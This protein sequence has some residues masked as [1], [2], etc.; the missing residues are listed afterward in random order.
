MKHG[1][2]PR[3]SKR[4]VTALALALVA[5][6]TE[7]RAQEAE[8]YT[9]GPGA[10]VFSRFG[11]AALCVRDA[12]SPGGRCYNY[13]TTDFS[14]P[15]P[16][17]WQVLRGRARFWVSVAPLDLMLAWYIAEDRTV[18]RQRVALAPDAFAA[19]QRRLREDMAPAS[20]AYVYHHFR[21]RLPF[22]RG[23]SG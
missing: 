18:W 15:G 1:A 21:D 23:P 6:T 14:T 11:H 4:A 8:V 17:T 5:A 3:V 2:P 16:L 10:D 9:M 12:E 13:G 7:A 19:L 20:R 22:A